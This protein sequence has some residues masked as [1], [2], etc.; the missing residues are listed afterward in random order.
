MRLAPP[1]IDRL[2][3]RN[4]RYPAPVPGSVPL[5]VGGSA[6]LLELVENKATTETLEY[7]YNGLMACLDW[8]RISGALELRNWRPGDQYRGWPF[9]RG[10]D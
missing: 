10:T 8:E 1:G 4:F 6:V 7:G 9:G 5:P 3:N 2:E